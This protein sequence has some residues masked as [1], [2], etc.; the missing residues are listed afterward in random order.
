MSNTTDY[1][2][3]LQAARE[4]AHVAGTALSERLGMARSTL[5]RIESGD[6]ALTYPEYV[7]AIAV[8]TTIARERLDAIERGEF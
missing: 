2:A 8:V 3:R 1:G 4:A 7:Q 6:K 5:S